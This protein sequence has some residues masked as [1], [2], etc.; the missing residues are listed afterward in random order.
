MKKKTYVYKL[1]GKYRRHPELL[2]DYG[3]DYFEDEEQDMAVFA[4]FV[5]I[6]QDNK[7]FQ[8]CVSI[9]ESMYDKA[10]TAEREEFFSDFKFVEELQ[11]DQKT[12][13]KLVLDEGLIDEFSLCQVCVTIKKDA[14]E[15]GVLFI[16][17]PL[18]DRYYN[19]QILQECAP[20]LI[21]KMVKNKVIYARRHFYNS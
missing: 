19:Y 6:G 17:S 20:E 11:P 14:D 5:R 15:P 4:Q 7:L 16:N 18:S 1:T 10:T 8:Q 12:V 2:Y 3:F 9:L 21:E 13:T